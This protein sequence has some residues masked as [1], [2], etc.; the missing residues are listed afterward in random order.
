MRAL[1]F[2]ICLCGCAAPS[3]PR[4][5]DLGSAIAA[6]NGAESS[7]TAS[8]VVRREPPRAPV[9]IAS[10]PEPFPAV[11]GR[12]VDARFHGAPLAHALRL[13]AEAADLGLVIGDG[14]EG[15]VS[16]DLRDVAPL[17]AMEAIAQAHGIELEIVGRTVIARR[18]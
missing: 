16:L 1:S 5:I 15:T 17:T 13:L 2:A 4:T 10:R 6:W 18:L 9:R 12:R 3:T 8:V 7:D 14:V 11:R